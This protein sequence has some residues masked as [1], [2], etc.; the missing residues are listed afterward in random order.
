[1][2]GMSGTA[3]L[4]GAIAVAVVAGLVLRARNGRLRTS[5]SPSGLPA[6][7]LAELDEASHVT[8]VMFSTEFCAS[9]KHT[10]VVLNGLAQDTD[11]IA[12]T[13]I[14]LT[15]KPQL[16]KELSVLRTPTTIAV[17]ADGT[18]LL[19]VGGLPKRDE[20]LDALRPH[21]S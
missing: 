3:V 6:E 10:R 15:D 1:M 20:L 5:A 8:L 11:G 19:R 21:L 12:H 17:S 13:E 4:V 14:D 2:T 9:C 18:E 16:A 7:V